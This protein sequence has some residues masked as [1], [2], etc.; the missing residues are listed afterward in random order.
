MP[1]K[2][3]RRGAVSDGVSQ[4][5]SRWSGDAALWLGRESFW[6]KSGVDFGA[7]VAESELRCA[8]PGYALRKNSCNAMSS[9]DRALIDVASVRRRTRNATV[10]LVTNRTP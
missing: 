7:E 6:R 2:S 9:H 8:V 10:L 4:Y 3:V 5:T 1:E